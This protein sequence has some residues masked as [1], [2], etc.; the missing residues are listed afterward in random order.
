MRLPCSGSAGNGEDVPIKLMEKTHEEATDQ[1]APDE[2][3]A[4]Q[5]VTCLGRRLSRN[6][7]MKWDSS[8]RSSTGNAIVIGDARPLVEGYVEHYNDVRLNSASGYMTPKDMLAGR[9]LEI[10]AEGDRKR[11]AARKVDSSPVDRVTGQDVSRN[12]SRVR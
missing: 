7:P 6:C 3:V 9:Q 12:N 8:P 2:K 10:H 4:I 11:E 1:Y 5:G